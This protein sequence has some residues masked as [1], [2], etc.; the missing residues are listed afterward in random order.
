MVRLHYIGHSAF[1]LEGSRKVLF[2][3]WL[4]GNP[5]AVWDL[6]KALEFSPDYIFISHGHGDH[7]FSD[8]VE[9]TKEK[10]QAVGVFELIQALTQR[11]GKGIGANIGGTLYLDGVKAYITPA[12]HSCPYATPA[13]YIVEMD[14]LTI[15]HAGD[16][17]LT[18]EMELLGE[19]F[20]IDVALLPIGGHFTMSYKEVK[21][22]KEMLKAKRYIGMHY[23]TFPPITIDV[24]EA[25]K[26]IEVFEPGAVIEL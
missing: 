15:Y 5:K 20:E 4:T 13:G 18:K 12:L 23:N 24:E 21:K 19:M 3:P 11:G 14:G 22:V 8:A 6:K 26:H 9:I 7:G 1:A 2:D 10:G 16:T 25:K 17:A